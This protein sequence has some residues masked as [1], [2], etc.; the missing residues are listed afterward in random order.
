MVNSATGGHIVASSIRCPGGCRV[1]WSRFAEA[2][3]IAAYAEKSHLTRG[4][5]LNDSFDPSGARS[6]STK[7]SATSV[8]RG[9]RASTFDRYHDEE[10]HHSRSS[11]M[12]NF[13]NSSSIEKSDCGPVVD[14]R[15]KVS[16]FVE[17]MGLC[18]N[19]SLGQKLSRFRGF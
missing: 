8:A 10:P 2:S 9:L 6:R 17:V 5:H 18:S 7:A 3:V 14:G 19:A 1:R 13:T 15:L 4:I 12:R 11:A 16:L